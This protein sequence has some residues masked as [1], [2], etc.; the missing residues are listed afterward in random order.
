MVNLNKPLHGKK[1]YAFLQVGSGGQNLLSFVSE[2]SANFTPQNLTRAIIMGTDAVPDT[3]VHGVTCRVRAELLLKPDE[4]DFIAMLK[5]DDAV[6]P[7]GS[8]PPPSTEDSQLADYSSA[9]SEVLAGT[10]YP[11]LSRAKLVLAVFATPFSAEI[12][13]TLTQLRAKAGFIIEVDDAPF[14]GLEFINRVGDYARVRLELESGL[15]RLEG[16]PEVVST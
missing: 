15:Y 10:G 3:E 8:A 6:F 7:A 2:W 11:V 13:E 4:L 16:T 9:V 5:P 14:A 12:I 1:A